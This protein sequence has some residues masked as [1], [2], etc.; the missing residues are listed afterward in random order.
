MLDPV[1]PDWILEKATGNFDPAHPTVEG[2]S[3]PPRHQP[4]ISWILDQGYAR[5][6]RLTESFVAK[7]DK[8]TAKREAAADQPAELADGAMFGD[9]KTG[10]LKFFERA[11]V[12]QKARM[13][14]VQTISDP[15]A[16]RRK[17]GLTYL[18][19]GGGSRPLT[20]KQIA[21]L[22]RYTKP[23]ALWS[24]Q[25]HLLGR[26]RRDVIEAAF[27]ISFDLAPGSENPFLSGWETITHQALENERH[28]LRIT[29]IEETDGYGL[30]AFSI[31]D[32]PGRRNGNV[33][34]STGAGVY[35][36]TTPK[37]Q[38][39]WLRPSF[40]EKKATCLLGKENGLERRLQ[41]RF[42]WTQNVLRKLPG[43]WT[44]S[45]ADCPRPIQRHSASRET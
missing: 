36:L 32:E 38:Q 39:A 33:E 5:Q 24:M 3:I 40:L 9:I 13:F 20:P 43:S 14:I 6:M 45:G 11:K 18:W 1:W 21:R 4:V 10:H 12:T 31:E 29:Q 19:G 42:H 41:V 44:V 2:L 35:V 34:L 7:Q 27:R 22:T 17:R 8:I 23:D 28:E 15:D 26:E 30:S 16:K 25:D 37:G